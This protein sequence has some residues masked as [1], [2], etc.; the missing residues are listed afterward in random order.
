LHERLLR[1][2]TSH[3]RHARKFAAELDAL[4]DPT[5]FYKNTLGGHVNDA[6]RELNARTWARRH[7][8]SSENLVDLTVRL[9]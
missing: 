2:R 4:G 9:T 8:Y 6:D 1:N 5:L 7:V 3:P